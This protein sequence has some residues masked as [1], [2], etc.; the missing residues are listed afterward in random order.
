MRSDLTE[1]HE[2]FDYLCALEALDQISSE[3][4]ITL[5]EHLRIC[6]ECRQ[7]L[8]EYKSWAAVLSEHSD[9]EAASTEVPSGMYGRFRA[10][11]FAQG[12]HLP[13]DRDS[14][15]DIA[16]VRHARFLIWA[17]AA[18]VIGLL[19]FVVVVWRPTI[20]NPKQPGAQSATAAKESILQKD[21]D[22]LR[23]RE[24]HAEADVQRLTGQIHKQT[25]QTAMIEAELS[26]ERRLSA[27]LD[28]I[29]KLMEYRDLRVI[30]L[31]NLKQGTQ[32]KAFGRAFCV[33]GRKLVLFAYDLSDPNALNARSFY[34]W[35]RR[36]ANEQPQALGR[37]KLENQKD[38]RWAIRIDSPDVCTT[39]GEVFI[40]IEPSKGKV[41]KPTG[42]PILRA[43]LAK[44]SP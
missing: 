11:A 21:N 19:I 33:P 12:I 20:H 3:E 5:R 29:R 30:Q 15:P 23:N 32:I 44:Y 35:E 10:R 6:P 2:Q 40:T 26:R 27:S 42:H 25:E 18:T 14:E 36:G 8:D 43:P 34:L 37:L 41:E 38:D 28:E 24:M 1:L 13:Q 7:A 4:R 16:R 9:A 31:N 17:S 22:D 39:T